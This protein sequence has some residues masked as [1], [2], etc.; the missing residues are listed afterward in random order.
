MLPPLAL[1]LGGAPGSVVLAGG[2]KLTQKALPGGSDPLEEKKK[3][4]EKKKSQDKSLGEELEKG[5]LHLCLDS[6]IRSE[7]VTDNTRNCSC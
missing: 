3:N 4:E 5:C 7:S 2:E 1:R 6:Q